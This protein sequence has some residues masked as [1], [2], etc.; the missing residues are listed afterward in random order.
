MII[1]VEDRLNLL[2][3]YEKY[4]DSISEE[5]LMKE[6]HNAGLENYLTD[7]FSESKNVYVIIINPD[8]LNYYKHKK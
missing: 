6:L 5:Q 8:K 3:E 2:G 4:I 7:E 1:K